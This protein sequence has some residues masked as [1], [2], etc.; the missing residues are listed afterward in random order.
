MEETIYDNISQIVDEIFSTYIR[1]I[2]KKQP[3]FI[4]I[5]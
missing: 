2:G 5:L 3:L 1:R 4:T